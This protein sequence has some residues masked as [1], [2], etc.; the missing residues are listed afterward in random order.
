M[1]VDVWAMPAFGVAVTVGV[2]A[3]ADVPLVVRWGSG[4]S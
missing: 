1:A 3:G 2:Y 4:P